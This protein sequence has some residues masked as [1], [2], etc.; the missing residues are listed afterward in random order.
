MAVNTSRMLP[1]L[2][3]LEKRCTKEILRKTIEDNYGIVTAVCN[4][5]DCTASQFYKALA[6]FGLEEELEKA[7]EQLA[8]RAE[9]TLLK[10]LDSDD[11]RIRLQA[12]EFIL[13][14]RGQRCGWTGSPS[15]QQIDI[16]NGQ[17]SIKQIF[18]IGEQ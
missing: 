11:E 18:G 14:M 4:M 17:V 6:H 9:S 16:Q 2:P 8:S 15:A 13:K 10:A 1:K 5:L 7:R 3:A 12:A